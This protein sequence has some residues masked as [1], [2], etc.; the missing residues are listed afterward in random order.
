MSAPSKIKNQKEEVFSNASERRKSAR[1]DIPIKVR[2]SSVATR[3]NLDAVAG[4]ISAGGCLL[5]VDEELGLDSVV[6]IEVLLGE[7]ENEILRLRGRVVRLNSS[8]GKK[9]EFGLAF[10]GMSKEARRLFADFCF[11]RMYEMIGLP[12]WPTAKK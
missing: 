12:E 9:F 11:A 7:S 1:L 6:E 10:D 4:N 5:I 3:E 8:D 2:Y